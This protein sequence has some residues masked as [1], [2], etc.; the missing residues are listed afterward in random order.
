MF[1][2]IYIFIRKGVRDFYAE[3]GDT[4]TAES[5]QRIIDRIDH[6]NSTSTGSENLIKEQHTLY[7]GIDVLILQYFGKKL[8]LIESIR[9]GST[10]S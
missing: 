2:F 3:K 8:L 9:Y 5:Y 10:K 6:N 4:K 1:I 7:F